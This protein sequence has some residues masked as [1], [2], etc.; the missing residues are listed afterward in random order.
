MLIWGLLWWYLTGLNEIDHFVSSS[1]IIATV[2]VFVAMSNLLIGKI[3]Q[4]LTWNHLLFAP[5]FLL[6]AMILLTILSMTGGIDYQ[7]THLFSGF[8]GIGW[9]ISFIA[10]Y[11]ILYIS[12]KTWPEKAVFFSH[13]GSWV[14]LIFICTWEFAYWTDIIFQ[15]RETWVF[16][17]YAMIPLAFS[18]GLLRYGHYLKWPVMRHEQ[19]YL[20]SGLILSIAYLVIW[21]VVITPF[22]GDPEPLPFIPILNPIELLQ[23]FIAI[24]LVTWARYQQEWLHSLQIDFDNREIR[25]TGCVAAFLLFNVVV[26]RTV[27][28]WAN[29][30]FNIS[31]LYSSLLYQ[32]TLSIIWGIMALVVTFVATQKGSRIIWIAGASIL[33]LVVAKLFLVDLAGTGTVA[34]IVSFLGVGGLMLLIGYLSPL[35]PSK[36]KQQNE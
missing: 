14:L 18:F 12:E 35:P 24:S 17:S 7:T 10:L 29:V 11:R 19:T 27:H 6:P 23:L 33:S 25:I 1:H 28:F 13:L 32:A 34:R 30:P 5:M 20:R 36:E 3:G 22:H 16:S 8:T 21:L 26:A 4:K 31:A 9:I 2:L 15:G